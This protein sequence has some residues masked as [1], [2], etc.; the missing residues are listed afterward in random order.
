[1]G[2]LELFPQYLQDHF[3][4]AYLTINGWKKRAP[5]LKLH[6]YQTYRYN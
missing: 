3:P 6:H 2:Q 5:F 4:P 1:M